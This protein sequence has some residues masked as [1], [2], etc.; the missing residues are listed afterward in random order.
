MENYFLG[1]D[2]GGSKTYAVIVDATGQEVGRGQGGSANFT[3]VGLEA[4]IQ[5]MQSAIEDAAR[6]AGCSLPLQKGWLGI[7]GIARQEDI[8]AL[9]PSLSKYAAILHITND[10]E[11]G[12]CALEQRVGVTIIAGTG[13]IALG[14]NAQGQKARAGGWGY[15]L[16]N[17]GSGYT[18]GQNALVAALQY[19]DGR[20]AETVLLDRIMQEWQLRRVEEVIGQVYA[21]T[22]RAI[23][24]R[25][26]RLVFEAARSGDVIAQEIVERNAYE[27]ARTCTALANRLHF[28]REGFPLALVG[29]LLVHEADYRERVL[30]H[31]R[32]TYS[33]GQL[34]IVAH[35]AL[36]AA[37]AAHTLP[38][39]ERLADAG[40]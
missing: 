2:C 37:R 24:A 21:P 40:N 36:S 29:G 33:I 25:L 19:A 1:L 17:E 13:S 14:R 18:I 9:L 16:G 5:Q 35:P 38:L 23:V 27:L 8:D 12:L 34:E 28:P 31:I 22:G 32:E 11:L 10:A 30:S 26:S 15:L 39:E 3:Q 6:N 7:A 20:G 4:A